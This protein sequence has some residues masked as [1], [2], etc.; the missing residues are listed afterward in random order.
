MGLFVASVIIIIIIIAAYYVQTNVLYKSVETLDNMT[1]VVSTAYP[2]Y[3]EAAVYLSNINKDVVK[4]MR[5]LKS[6]YL[7]YT[8]RYND[9][10]TNPPTEQI[11]ALGLV[12]VEDKYLV[13]LTRGLCYGYNPDVII[14]NP[15]TN[16]DTAYTL[17]KGKKLYLCLRDRVDKKLLPYEST[18]FVTIHELAH[19]SARDIWQH[20]PDYWAVFKFLL[21]EADLAGVLKPR[22]YAFDP[23]NYCGLDIKYNPLFDPKIVTLW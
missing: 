15:P 12:P 5:H 23:F 3:K 14:E 1:Y 11:E 6:K 10:Y 17:S 20:G 19:I 4:L 18:L 22:N 8:N 9:I 21:H 13:K 16:K 7:V 2:D